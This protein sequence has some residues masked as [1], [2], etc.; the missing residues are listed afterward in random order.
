MFPKVP[1]IVLSIKLF[2]NNICGVA[3]YPDPARAS[4][5][6]DYCLFNKFLHT[7]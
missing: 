2:H 3:Y 5:N 4:P 6:N 7:T 1:S